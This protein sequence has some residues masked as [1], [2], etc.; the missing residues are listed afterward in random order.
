[1]YF[2]CVTLIYN[3]VSMSSKAHKGNK[4]TYAPHIKKRKS[5]TQWTA[6][7]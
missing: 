5:T 1:M 6:L 4:Q 3:H 7:M 2:N